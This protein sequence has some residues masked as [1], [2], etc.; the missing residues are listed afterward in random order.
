ML[1]TEVGGIE[2]DRGGM[3]RDCGMIYNDTRDIDKYV[4]ERSSKLG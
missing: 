2:I 4:I 3:Q 1:S